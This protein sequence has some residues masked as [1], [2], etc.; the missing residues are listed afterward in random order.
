MNEQST[1]KLTLEQVKGGITALT[2]VLK[3]LR[4]IRD[5]EAQTSWD[6]W[7]EVL[8]TAATA[9]LQKSVALRHEL[10]EAAEKTEA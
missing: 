2:N 7:N 3:Y 8:S 4:Q 1:S 9:V 6:A 10:L 5:D